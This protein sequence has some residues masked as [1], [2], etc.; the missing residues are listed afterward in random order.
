MNHTETPNKPPAPSSPPDLLTAASMPPKEGLVKPEP[1]E[2]DD[3][4]AAMRRTLT[5]GN[6]AEFE[7]MLAAQV[8]LMHMTF[9]RFITGELRSQYSP[10]GN[11]VD[12]ALKAQRG[13]CN[14]LNTLRRLRAGE[15]GKGTEGP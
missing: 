13:I 5:G 9:N 8:Q 3:I 1:V 4:V 15:S 10:N 6:F 12:I 14:T 2:L 11:G 7:T